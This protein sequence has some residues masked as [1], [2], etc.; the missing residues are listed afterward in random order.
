MPKVTLTEYQRDQ[1]TVESIIR[2]YAGAQRISLPTLAKKIPIAECQ[3]Y[4]RLNYP[5]TF[6]RGEL[7]R[8]CK[9]L[10]I[11]DEE[12]LMLL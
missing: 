5:D 11:P 12:K 2:K 9:I 3:I 1:E 4:K 10:H 7:K 8:I 6:R